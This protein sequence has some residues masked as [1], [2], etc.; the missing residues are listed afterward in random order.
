MANTETP[1]EEWQITGLIY[2]VANELQGFVT[3]DEKA[4]EII[5]QISLLRSSGKLNEAQL[6]ILDGM[7]Q[8]KSM[9][10]DGF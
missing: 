9:D 10:F 1:L 6:K 5:K 7:G 3:P 2:K 8:I 4:N